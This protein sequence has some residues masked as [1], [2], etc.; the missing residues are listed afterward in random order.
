LALLIFTTIF[1]LGKSKMYPQGK[2]DLGQPEVESI[3]A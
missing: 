2:P 1:S 3:D